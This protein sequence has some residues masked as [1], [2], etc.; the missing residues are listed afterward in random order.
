MTVMEMN[1][2]ENDV[3]VEKPVILIVDDNQVNQLVIKSLLEASAS[4]IVVAENG[5]LAVEVFKTGAF[6]YVLMDI[7]MPVMDGVTAAR[8]IR[9]YERSKG[10]PE[11]PIIAVTAH[12]DDDHR[13]SCESAGMNGF[14]P[15][16]VK[17]TQLLEQIRACCLAAAGGHVSSGTIALA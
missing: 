9:N 6:N 2:A 17:A 3:A 1:N 11:T 7:N 10:A 16:P 12:D 14:V 4:K 5:A 13:S 8:E 15:K